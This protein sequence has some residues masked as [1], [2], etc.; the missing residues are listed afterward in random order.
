[1]GVDKATD[2]DPTS[3]AQVCN[4]SPPCV[5]APVRCKT[6]AL[7]AHSREATGMNSPS[8]ILHFC[9]IRTCFDWALLPRARFL[10]LGQIFGSMSFSLFSQ[11]VVFGPD[12]SFA[13]F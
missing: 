6:H 13:L 9:R 1:G 8:T 4:F 11:L 12:L 3:R 2:S 10:A 5:C 7:V